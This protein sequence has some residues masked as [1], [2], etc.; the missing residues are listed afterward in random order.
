VSYHRDEQYTVVPSLAGLSLAQAKKSIW[1]SGLNIGKVD[2]DNS[3]E[4]IIMYRK[5]KVYRQSLN[6]NASAARGSEVNL[7]LSCNEELIDSAKL[8]AEAEMKRY[9]K[10]RRKAEQE[11][12]EQEAS[13]E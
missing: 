7:Y 8:V 4:D 2:Y 9:E 1:D 13:K 3:V 11:R 12:R 5:A 6:Q 10:Q